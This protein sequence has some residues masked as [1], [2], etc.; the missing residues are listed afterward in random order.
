MPK[1]DFSQVTLLKPYFGM[2]VLKFGAIPFLKNTFGGLLLAFIFYTQ[3][4]VAETK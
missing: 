3:S 4:R 1:C 2:N